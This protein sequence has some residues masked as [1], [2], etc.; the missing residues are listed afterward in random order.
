[1]KNLIKHIFP[2]IIFLLAFS[3]DKNETVKPDD[4]CGDNT[5][6]FIRN[7]RASPGAVIDILSDTSMGEDWFG[8]IPGKTYHHA[9][10]AL[11]DSTL[12][13]ANEDW[14]KA[15]NPSDSVFYFNYVLANI[16][17]GLLCKMCCP[18][19]QIIIITSFASR[20]CPATNN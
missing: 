2:A 8:G 16:N 17:A 12:S 7:W 4:K 14:S 13:K 11:L 6:K 20:P 1:M 18:P 15:M 19:K 10:L 5:A 9:V 3:C